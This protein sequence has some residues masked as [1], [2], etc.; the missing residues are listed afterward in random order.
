METDLEK[1]VFKLEALS[2][3]ICCK[4]IANAIHYLHSFNPPVLHRDIKLSNILIDSK[5]VCKLS[6]KINFK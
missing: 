5:G 3:L 6:G 2:K 4:Q 1:I